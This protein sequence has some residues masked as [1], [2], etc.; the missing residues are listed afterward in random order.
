MADSRVPRR[1]RDERGRPAVAPRSHAL[2][3]GEAVA[4]S[5]CCQRCRNA[6]RSGRSNRGDLLTRLRE[7][8]TSRVLEHPTRAPSRY[9]AVLAVEAAARASP[10]AATRPGASRPMPRASRTAR[11]ISS[12]R[13]RPGN[14]EPPREDLAAS[15]A[16][17]SATAP[18]ATRGTTSATDLGVSSVPARTTVPAS[19]PNAAA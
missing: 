9:R 15:R 1:R 8:P 7:C 16:A 2:V 10:L 12:T 6:T 18:E 13:Y 17:S 3:P 14:R 4:G 19:R 11:R 5:R